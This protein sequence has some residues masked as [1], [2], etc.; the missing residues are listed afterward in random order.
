MELICSNRNHCLYSK[1]LFLVE[2]V[3]FNRR[4]SPANICWSSTRLQRLE[5]IFKRCLQDVFKTCLQDILS[6]RLEDVFSV[7]I[8]RLPR[9]LEDVLETSWRHLEDIFKTSRKTT[10]RGLQDVLKDEKLLCWRRLHDVLKTC[11]EDILKTC[12]ED[13]LKTYLEDVFMMSRKQTKFLL[14]ISGPNKSKCASNK[15]L[16]HKLYL[17]NLRRIQNASLRT[18]KSRYSSYFETHQHFCFKN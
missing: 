2:A 9:R 15:S 4:H 14:V 3:I 10:W 1:R 7:T 11:L 17:R 16:F 8:L 12:L 13:V 5:D 6:R 18:Q